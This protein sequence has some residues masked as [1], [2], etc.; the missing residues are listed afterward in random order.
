MAE[1]LETSVSA[2]PRK[3]FF[4]DLFTRDISLEDCILDLIDNSIDGLVRS[5]NVHPAESAFLKKRKINKNKLPQVKIFL[6]EKEFKIQD[7]CG[8]IPKDIAVNEAFNFGR[9]RTDKH[10]TLGVYGIG[11]KRAIF[12]IGNYFKV[13]SFTSKENFYIYENVSKWAERDDSNIENWKF[14]CVTLVPFRSKKPYGTTI[15]VTELKDDVKRRIGDPSFFVLLKQLISKTYPYLLESQFR[16]ILNGNIIEPDEIPLAHSDDLEIGMDKL[17]IENTKITIVVG[18]AKKEGERD[19][20]QGENSGWYILCNGRVIVRANKDEETGWG[21]D[22]LLPTYQPKHR[23]FIGIVFF[24]SKNGLELPWKTTKHGV[25]QE[26]KIYQITRQKM[27]TNAKPVLNFINKLYPSDNAETP[28][29]RELTKSMVDYD[30]T[31]LP[32]EVKKIFKVSRQNDLAVNKNEVRIQFWA[33]KSEVERIRKYLRDPKLSAQK[34]GLLVF[35][36]YS[37]NI[38][39]S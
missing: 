33:K 12:K 2:I 23:G 10:A 3:K 5:F 6:T 28:L 38:V 39:E 24:N 30:F 18:L 1:G 36:Y 11:L 29:E 32:Q 14:P 13:E 25:N 19:V 22:T 34:I 21:I 15:T 35:D 31:D 7:E 37:K 17:E 9:L 20:W 27:S 16:V 8:G 4:I 26:S